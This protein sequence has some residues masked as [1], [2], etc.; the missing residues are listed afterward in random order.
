MVPFL[1]VPNCYPKMNALPGF[2]PENGQCLLCPLMEP[3][4]T[5]RPGPTSEARNCNCSRSMLV[6][7]KAT[8]EIGS[9]SWG[10]KEPTELIV[11]CF[12][13]LGI[14]GG[15]ISL[16]HTAAIP[17]QCFDG[18]SLRQGWRDLDHQ[19]R[20]VGSSHEHFVG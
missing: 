17:S 10:T 1:L 4:I 2:T 20:K 5:T 19:R 6:S 7:A 3:Q 15:L 14:Y 18:W 12:E 9:S 11:S 13:T 8:C 16:T